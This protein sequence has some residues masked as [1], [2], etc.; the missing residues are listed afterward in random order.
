M[1]MQRNLQRRYAFLPLGMCLLLTSLLL[2]ACGGPPPAKT[3]TIGAANYY[4]ALESVLE[5]FKAKMA[6]LVVRAHN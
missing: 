4:P 2:T 6:T 3:Y 5:S 1:H